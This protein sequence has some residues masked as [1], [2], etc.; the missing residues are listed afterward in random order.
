M[1]FF[2]FYFSYTCT[3]SCLLYVAYCNSLKV[4]GQ[5]PDLDL[6]LDLNLVGPILAN[7]TAIGEKSIVSIE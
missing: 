6:D 7:I 5:V 4:V 1:F 3:L 2:Y